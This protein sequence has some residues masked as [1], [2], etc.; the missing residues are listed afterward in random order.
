VAACSGEFTWDR[1]AGR[2]QL[3]WV[4][5]FTEGGHTMSILSF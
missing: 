1:R 2:Q 4:L 5:P 3:I